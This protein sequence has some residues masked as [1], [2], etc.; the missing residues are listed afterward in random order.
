[1]PRKKP[2]TATAETTAPQKKA[3]RAPY[4]D[5]L[6]KKLDITLRVLTRESEHI[7][8]H[9]GNKQTERLAAIGK[10]ASEIWTAL[11]DTPGVSKLP[12][13]ARRHVVGAVAVA[14]QVL[15]IVGTAYRQALYLFGEKVAK[16]PWKVDSLIEGGQL[17]KLVSMVDAK[18]ITVAPAR[19]ASGDSGKAAEVQAALTPK[20][21]LV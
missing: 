9:F 12:P 11:R 6:R 8:K 16:G 13:P 2:A 18:I 20:N 21:K 7:Y 10:E 3:Q 14:G 1:M 5:R 15:S 17:L 4:P 19:N